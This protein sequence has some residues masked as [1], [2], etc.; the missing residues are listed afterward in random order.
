MPAERDRIVAEITAYWRQAGLPQRV[1]GEMRSELEAHLEEAASHGAEAGTVVSD[2]ARLAEEW[3]GARAGRLVPS[4]AEVQSG[5]T[6]KR[7]ANRRD[8]VLYG[9]AAV[10]LASAAAAAG[11]GGQ[12]VDNETWRWVWTIFALFMGIG[13][14]FTAGFFLLPFATGAAAAAILAWLNVS[15]I[16]QWLVFF[17]VSAFAFAFLRRYI[18]RQDDGDQPSIGANRWVGAEGVVLEAVDP[19]SGAGMV[20][21]LNEEWRAMSMSRIEIGTRVIV[22]DVRGTRLM[23][24]PIED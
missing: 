17:G 3:A 9:I 10:A 23:V 12:S 16:A 14:M 5:T 15:L 6:S 1:V 4:W 24:E 18:G 8:T 2:L 21:V 13:E 19:T 20:R 7:R 11:Q 22:V